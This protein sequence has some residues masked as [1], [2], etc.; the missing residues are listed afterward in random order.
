[1]L[2]AEDASWMH[3][4]HGSTSI[5]LQLSNYTNNVVL[6]YVSISLIKCFLNGPDHPYFRLYK[7]TAL[8]GLGRSV[9]EHN[10]NKQ[11]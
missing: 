2:N 8:T 3:W 6:G 4:I 10:L 9:C 1:M 5:S 7:Q 11:H